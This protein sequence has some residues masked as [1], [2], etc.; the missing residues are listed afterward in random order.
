MVTNALVTAFRR[1]RQVNLNL[2]LAWSTELVT[3]KRNPILKIE[4]NQAKLTNQ[5]NKQ[6]MCS[7]EKF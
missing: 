1:W 3:G 2:R 4:P 5:P 6:K 7:W